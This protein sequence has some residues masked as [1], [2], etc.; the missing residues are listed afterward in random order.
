MSFEHGTSKGYDAHR[1]AGE[2]PCD[3]CRRANADRVARSRARDVR[4]DVIR[5]ERGRALGAESEADLLG[6]LRRLQGIVTAALEVAK[7]SEVPALVKQAADLAGRI[8]DLARAEADSE[9]DPFAVFMDQPLTLA[10]VRRA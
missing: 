1:R 9:S 6:E 4:D 3:A 8:D 10:E 2:T 5:L 7:P